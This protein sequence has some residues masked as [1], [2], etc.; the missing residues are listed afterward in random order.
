MNKINVN[1][2]YSKLDSLNIVFKDAQRL[3]PIIQNLIEFMR[4]TIPMLENINKS[5]FE[6]TYKIPRATN[7]IND[8]TSATE[9]ATTEILDIVDIITSDI[10]SLE[11]STGQLLV[12]EHKRVSILTK[13]KS[14]A[15]ENKEIQNLFNE[16]DQLEVKE[17]SLAELFESSKKI[18]ENV[19]N[20]TLSLQVQDITTQQLAAVNHLIESVQNKLASIIVHFEGATNIENRNDFEFPE[21]SHFNPDAAYT[22]SKDNQKLVDDL[23]NVGNKSASQDEIDKLFLK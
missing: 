9:M 14:L 8:V 1:A 15:K 17:N 7:Q 10:C 23:I 19:H 6:S 12:D 2:L 13:I 16:F 20:I 4:D 5:V 11:I 18:R 22:K 3:I 21:E